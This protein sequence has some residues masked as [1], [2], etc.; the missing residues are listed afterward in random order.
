MNSIVGF[1]RRTYNE[2]RLWFNGYSEP[3][4]VAAWINF[5]VYFKPYIL[6]LRQEAMATMQPETAS[7]QD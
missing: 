6:N 4:K 3:Q 1:I 5:L 7:S 2:S